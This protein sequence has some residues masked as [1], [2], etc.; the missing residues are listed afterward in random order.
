[1]LTTT[2]AAL[3]AF[4][5]SI[6]LIP[7]IIVYIPSDYFI[8]PKRQKYLPERHPP[9]L[10]WM[11]IILKNLIGTVLIIAGIIML[12]TPGQGLLSII[13]GLFLSNFPY[14]YKVEKWI[15]S[16][17]IFF[18]TLNKIRIKAGKEPFQKAE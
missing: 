3:I 17:P 13:A 9:L 1:M 6:A 12:F 14:K 16:R 8:H 4:V 15:I 5:L 18:N 7:L 10:Q 11:F 2:L